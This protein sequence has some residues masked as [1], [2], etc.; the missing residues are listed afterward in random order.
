MSDEQKIFI[1][2]IVN[3]KQNQDT[4]LPVLVA[5]VKQK[6]PDLTNKEI[7]HQMFRVLCGQE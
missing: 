3:R 1:K 6:Y 5:S 2:R 4:Q 7:E